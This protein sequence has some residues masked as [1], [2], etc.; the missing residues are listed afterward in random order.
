MQTIERGLVDVDAT[1]RTGGLHVDAAVEHQR[2]ADARIRRHLQRLQTSAAVAADRDPRDV[3]VPAKRAA[4]P[5]VL[6]RGPVDRLEGCAALVSSG[7]RRGFGG[8]TG[9]AGGRT[10]A[11]AAGSNGRSS[12]GRPTAITK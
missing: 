8:V 6:A 1:A 4:V 5:R 9:G 12:R 10:G 3:D 7:V 2:R 11:V